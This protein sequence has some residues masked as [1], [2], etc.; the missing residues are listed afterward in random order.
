MSTT[1]VE[2]KQE[3]TQQRLRWAC[4][5][6]MLELDILLGDFAELVYPQLDRVDQLR[7]QE[8]LLFSDQDLLEYCLGKNKIDSPELEPII[9]KIRQAAANHS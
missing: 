4:R 1:T 5:R 6:G 3:Q 7:F 2:E 9:E 8:L